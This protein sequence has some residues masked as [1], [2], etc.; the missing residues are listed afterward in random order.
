MPYKDDKFLQADAASQANITGPEQVSKCSFPRKLQQA[1]E[2][3]TLLTVTERHTVGKG[4]A[5][6]TASPRSD[7]NSTR[8]A[9]SNAARW[10][11]STLPTKSPSTA[12]AWRLNCNQ[13]TATLLAI[14]LIQQ[15]AWPDTEDDVLV[16]ITTARSS[17][18]DA[19]MLTQY[20]CVATDACVHTKN[21]EATLGRISTLL[22]AQQHIQPV[23]RL[24]A[25][26]KVYTVRRMQTHRITSFRKT[27]PQYQCCRRTQLNAQ[28]PSALICNVVIQQHGPKGVGCMRCKLHVAILWMS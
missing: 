6:I 27:A 10:T 5:Y 26:T 21:I 18:G 23:W 16:Q 17:A 1:H 28:H 25:I 11:P 13:F 20:Y 7:S 4:D 24:R 3:A 14:C 12:I 9:S 15:T 8:Q 19:A 2:T 22:V